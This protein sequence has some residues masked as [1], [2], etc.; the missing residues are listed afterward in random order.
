MDHLGSKRSF[1]IYFEMVASQRMLISRSA[2]IFGAPQLA[3]ADK[4]V[5]LI[6]LKLGKTRKDRAARLIGTGSMENMNIETDLIVTSLGYDSDAK[7]VGSPDF[8]WFDQSNGRNRTQL[9]GG[10]VISISPVTRFILN[11]YASGWASSGA[12]GILDETIFD[13]SNVALALIHDWQ[14]CGDR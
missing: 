4:R 13:A 8:P 3:L 10:R 12:R 14:D 7:N 11:I 6:Q 9:I 1:W 5:V 2:L